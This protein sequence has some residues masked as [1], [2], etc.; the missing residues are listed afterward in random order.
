MT[1]IIPI[2]AKSAATL[3]ILGSN[4]LIMGE[5]AELGP[6]DTQIS[7]TRE[8]SRRYSSAL[9][10]FKTLEELKRFA[11]ETFDIMVKFILRRADFSIKE[12]VKL[13]ID[14]VSQISTPLFSQLNVEKMGEYS[15]A[16]EVGREYGDR[17]LRR[18]TKYKDDEGRDRILRKLIYGYPS[19]SYI[20]DYKE[21]EE[22]G[23]DVEVATKDTKKILKKIMEY[24]IKSTTTEIFLIEYEEKE[25]SSK[26]MEGDNN[27]DRKNL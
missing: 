11:L 9:N 23:F 12:A 20:I 16:L 24:V 2:Y 14:F 10:P 25:A 8:G 15:R 3:F 13:G 22:I 18:F 5:L 26:K 1:T 19:H 7:E 6:L 17:L 27:G 4:G 21:I